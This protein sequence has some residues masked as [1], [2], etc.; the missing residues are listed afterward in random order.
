MLV[1]LDDVT[2]DRRQSLPSLA[3]QL[4]AVL[5]VDV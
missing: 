3:D 4:D 2:A 1:D 5:N